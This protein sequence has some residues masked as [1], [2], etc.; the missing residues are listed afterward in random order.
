MAGTPVQAAQM[1]SDQP[2]ASPTPSASPQMGS[3]LAMSRGR[4]TPYQTTTSPYEAM[5]MA[6]SYPGVNSAQQPQYSEA[7]NSQLTREGASQSV[8]ATETGPTASSGGTNNSP[9]TQYN[10]GAGANRLNGVRPTTINGV[11]PTTGRPNANFRYPGSPIYTQ[12]GRTTSSFMGIASGDPYS[13]YYSQGRQGSQPTGQVGNGGPD[14][15]STSTSDEESEPTE[16]EDEESVKTESSS[17]VGGRRIMN[18][19]DLS[20]IFPD[21]YQEEQPAS[22]G[23]MTS[24]SLALLEMTTINSDPDTE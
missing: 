22:Y 12:S 7:F 15:S 5:D 8:N 6:S 11:R 3:P 20:H 14:N 23:D 10:G 9:T 2:L 1:T 17:T 21:I 24:Q 4:T 19:Y 16:D 13:P 18:P